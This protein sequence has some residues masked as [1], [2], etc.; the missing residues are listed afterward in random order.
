MTIDRKEAL[1]F[2]HRTKDGV[3]DEQKGK[4]TVFVIGLP[5]SGKTSCCFDLAYRGIFAGDLPFYL[6]FSDKKDGSLAWSRRGAAQYEAVLTTMVYAR[7]PF[8]VCLYCAEDVLLKRREQRLDATASPERRKNQLDPRRVIIE[9]DEF[10]KFSASLGCK[11]IDVSTL[12]ISETA[13]E[14]LY[15]KKNYK[16]TRR[17]EPISPI[18]YRR[19]ATAQRMAYIIPAKAGLQ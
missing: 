12:G 4:A 7:L 16:P 2:F 11:V 8:V 6:N 19:R 3:F 14:I 10:N 17:P 9:I 1:D 13:S 18:D 15:W 5:G